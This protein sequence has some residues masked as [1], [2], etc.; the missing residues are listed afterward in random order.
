MVNW[1]YVSRCDEQM[2]TTSVI[3]P[4][5]DVRNT[6][7]TEWWRLKH[8]QKFDIHVKWQQNAIFHGIVEARC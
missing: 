6:I 5:G 4:R 3:R 8:I 7:G 2:N 1:K